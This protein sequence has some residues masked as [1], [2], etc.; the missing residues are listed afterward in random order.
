MPRGWRPGGELRGQGYR[1]K[2][3]VMGRGRHSLP[4]E[5]GDAEED[6]D[7]GVEVAAVTQVPDARVARPKQGLQWHTRLLDQLPLANPLVHIYLQLSH[8]LVRLQGKGR[9]RQGETLSPEFFTLILHRVRDAT[10]LELRM[11]S[12]MASNMGDA[13]AISS[14]SSRRP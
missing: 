6:L 2:G 8:G 7:H 13:L 5:V 9:F 3:P 4:L 1:A 11:C 10:L 12:I 14:P